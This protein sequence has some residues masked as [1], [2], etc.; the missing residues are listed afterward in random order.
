M[1]SL[2]QADTQKAAARVVL[3]S[4]C[5]N[6]S[7]ALRCDLCQLPVS[8][9]YHQVPLKD[10]CLFWYHCNRAVIPKPVVG[11]V[12]CRQRNR[13]YNVS[14]IERSCSRDFPLTQMSGFF[15]TNAWTRKRKC[16]N[17]YSPALKK[18]CLSLNRRKIL[19][20][21]RNE[22][23]SQTWVMPLHKM[24]FLFGCPAVNDANE[25]DTVWGVLFWC[26]LPPHN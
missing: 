23:H 25:R 20:Q 22:K 4:Y 1:C 7:C 24:S 13:A 10:W 11:D 21:K 8:L 17:L 19:C 5:Q 3:F 26:T 15:P 6:V 2:R 18:Y 14:P 16:L 9:L 12:T